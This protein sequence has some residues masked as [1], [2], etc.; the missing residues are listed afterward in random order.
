MT[1]HKTSNKQID[2]NKRRLFTFYKKLHEHE[3]KEHKTVA[4]PPYAV[5]EILFKRL[6]TGCGNCQAACPNE[7]INIIDGLAEI[8]VSYTPCDV[9]GECQKACQ[10]LALS[11][12]ETATGLIARISSTCDNL[13]SYCNNCEGTCN[14]NALIWQENRTPSIDQEKCIGCGFCITTCFINAISMT[15]A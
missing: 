14:F 10:T 12:Q 5:E 7:I 1:R 15:M 6:C 2:L 13:T 3:A 8:D 4:R 11:Q 9:C